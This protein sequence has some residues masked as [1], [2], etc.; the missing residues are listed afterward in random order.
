MNK[1]IIAS[2]ARGVDVFFGSEASE[3]VTIHESDQV[4]FNLCHQDIDSQIKFTVVNK[5][6]LCLIMLDNMTLV[7]WDVL[8]FSGYEDSLSLTLVLWLYDQSGTTTRALLSLLDKVVEIEEFIRGDPGLR[9]EVE[10][11]REGFLHQLQILCEVMFQGN[12]IHG[13]EVINDLMSFH[14]LK[15]FGSEYF[16]CPQ[17]IPF[18]LLARFL[19]FREF[20]TESLLGYSFYYRITNFTRVKYNLWIVFLRHCYH[21]CCNHFRGCFECFFGILMP[22]LLLMI[23]LLKRVLQSIH[24]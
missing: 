22:L 5:V 18:G 10:L 14:S 16:I 3:T 15:F 7:S 17:H 12:Q 2:A 24:D 6:R 8:H 4:R 9:E 20:P 11:L 13:R 23:L 1:E 21:L 19:T